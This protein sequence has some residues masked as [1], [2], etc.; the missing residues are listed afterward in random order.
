MLGV[1]DKACMHAKNT[2][3]VLV[4]STPKAKGQLKG[5]NSVNIWICCNQ[6]SIS[7]FKND[8]HQDSRGRH[9]LC[10]NQTQG[11]PKCCFQG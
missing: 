5:S 9:D 11:H 7:F 8:W 10:A 6:C 1:K 2:L 4:A 3:L